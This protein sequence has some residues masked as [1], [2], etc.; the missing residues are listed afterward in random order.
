MAS[1]FKPVDPAG[2][3]VYILG[4]Q[5]DPSDPRFADDPAVV[6]Y[7]EDVAEF[8]GGGDAANA[9]LATGYN[10][11]AVLVDVLTRA[12]AME[13][14]LTR[15]NIMNAAWS[16]DFEVPL[17]VG[18]RAKLDGIKDAYSA[19]FTE[20][21]QYDRGDGFAG[22]DRRHLRRGGQ[23]RRV[24][25]RLTLTRF[26][27]RPPSWGPAPSRPGWCMVRFGAMAL[28]AARLAKERPDEVALRD[29]L[30]ALRGRR[31][32]DGFNRVANGLDA[33][34]LGDARRVAVFAENAAETVLAHLG[35]LLAGVSSVR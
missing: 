35:G 4:Q 1:F 17:V 6:Q 23:V 11:G 25:G 15:A 13:G 20:M 34:D 31:S 8:G 5:K 14:G 18:G 9:Q 27:G 26:W 10:D 33:L 19:E 2:D 3:G 12:A 16:I 21:L 30:V 28:V 7:K 32:N 24:P 22:S 29:D